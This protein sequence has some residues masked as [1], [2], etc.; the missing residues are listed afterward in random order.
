MEMLDCYSTKQ[1]IY[2]P[3]A[4]LIDLKL[5]S[6]LDVSPSILGL[7]DPFVHFR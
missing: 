6:E 5:V 1:S 2:R 7:D 3:L 4:Y